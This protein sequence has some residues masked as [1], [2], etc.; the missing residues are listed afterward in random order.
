MYVHPGFWDLIIV[1]AVYA[2][3]CIH[4]ETHFYRIY[5]IYYLV[6]YRYIYH[7]YKFKKMHI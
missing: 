1:H 6:Q 5:Y 3:A 7:I 4:Y 2:Y